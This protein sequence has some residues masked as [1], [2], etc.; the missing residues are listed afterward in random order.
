VNTPDIMRRVKWLTQALLISGTLNIGLMTTFIYF[1]LQEKNRTIDFDLKPASIPL[2][3]TNQ[4]LLRAYSTLSFQELLLRLEDKELVEEGFSKRDLS[5]SCLVAFH[6]FDIEKALGGSPL[7]KRQIFLSS[8]D[9]LENVGLALFPD[10]KDAHYQAICHHA[11][12]EKWPLTSRGLFYEIGRNKQT[13]DPALLDT[14]F[15]TREFEAVSL[16]LTRAS[17]PIDKMTILS[18]LLEGNWELLSRFAEEQKKAQDLTPNKRV[19]FL[20]DY[21]HLRSKHAAKLLLETDFEF[22]CKRLDDP[23]ALLLL[24]LLPE[25]TPLVEKFAKVLLISPRS[26]TVWKQ[27]ALKLYTFAGEPPLE[28]FNRELALKRFIPQALQ[29]HPILTLPKPL[30][31]KSQPPSLP[32]KKVHIVK[33]GESLWK[34]SKL[35]RV[36]IEEIMRLNRLESEKLRPGKELLIP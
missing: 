3:I 2:P 22:V 17:T 14:F 29:K 32:K 25:R 28:P 6:H 31:P 18:L 33:E 35:H 4:E 30:P 9:G 26:D 5:L 20:I 7:Q 19:A 1:T 10:M 34:I 15:L 8:P 27:A 13:P 16:L 11:K 24:Q 12:V 23:H 21:I 36:S